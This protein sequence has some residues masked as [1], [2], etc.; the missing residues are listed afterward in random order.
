MNIN[1]Q[2]IMN[3][4][5]ETNLAKHPAWNKGWPKRCPYHPRPKTPSP[6]HPCPKRPIT[7]CS[8]ILGAVCTSTLFVGDRHQGTQ[9]H[10]EP[11]PNGDH[12]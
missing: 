12:A 8:T 10:G 7:D 6:K 11:L 5:L 3:N 9:H 1:L 2:N 4:R